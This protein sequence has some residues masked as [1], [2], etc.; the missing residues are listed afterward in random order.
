MGATLDWSL[1][2]AAALVGHSL[3]ADLPLRVLNGG[4]VVPD[5]SAVIQTAGKEKCHVESKATRRP[6]TGPRPR[7][8][9]WQGTP[10]GPWTA[11]RAA[12]A[13]SSGVRRQYEAQ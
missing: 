1:K 2:E 8:P 10:G 5:T 11:C 3:D 9:R 4:V 12:S 13:V 6:S 7:T